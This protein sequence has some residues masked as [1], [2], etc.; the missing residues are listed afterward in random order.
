MI[1]MIW[2]DWSKFR[3]G[4]KQQENGAKTEWSENKHSEESRDK[5]KREKEQTQR[6]VG[7]NKKENKDKTKTEQKQRQ[8]LRGSAGFLTRAE[9]EVT[10][11]QLGE[12]H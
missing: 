4:K 11:L 1:A 6:G 2:T 12:Q 9:Y 3:M 10:K 8:N 5:H 7:I